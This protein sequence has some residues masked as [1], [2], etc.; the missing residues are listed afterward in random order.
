M[1]RLL[2]S[3]LLPIILVSHCKQ[4]TCQDIAPVQNVIWPAIPVLV[5][6]EVTLPLPPV[7]P[8]PV[9]TLKGDE[10]LVVESTVQLI[11]RQ[12][13]EGLV[14]IEPS[15]G[16]I[17][18]RAKFSDGSGKIETREYRTA[19][20]YFLTS[21]KSGTVGIDLIPVGVLQEKGIERHTLTVIDGTQPNPGPTPGPGPDPDPDPNPGPTPG[22]GP[23]PAP[24]TSFRVIFVK[25]SRANL[26]PE[27]TA[28]PG[29]K[30]IRD[31][32]N[33]KATTE[34]NLAGW[35][36]YDPDQTTANEQPTMKA[37]W[38]AVKTK[39]LPAPCMVIEV[40]G[41]ATVMPFPANVDEALATLKKAGG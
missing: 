10:F 11:I 7:Q 27:Q 15:S 36:E 35:R 9:S 17:K 26:S 37:L 18:V 8:V 24:V 41:H 34:A 2:T 38:E 6:P 33:A 29:A 5:E 12:F 22:P 16:P 40:N 14:N 4:V 19:Y 31:Y 25:E 20:V 1:L 30:A 21:V 28:I 32:L 3:L 39:L 13:P 23:T